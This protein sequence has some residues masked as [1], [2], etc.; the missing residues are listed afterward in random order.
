MVA[1]AT[2]HQIVIA[3]ADPVGARWELSPPAATLHVWRRGGGL[4]S[5][6]ALADAPSGDMPLG[7]PLRDA[8]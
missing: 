8:A 1:P 7:K 2:A 6:I 4:M 5:R 3:D